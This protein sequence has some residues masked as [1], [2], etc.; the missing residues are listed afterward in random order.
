MKRIESMGPSILPY[1]VI[2]GVLLFR[3]EI[4]HPYN[5]V[6]VSSCL[7]IFAATRAVR[8]FVLPLSALVGVDIFLTT[9][10]YGYPL[11]F[12]AVVT[13]AFYLAAMLLGSGLLRTS[14][15]WRCVAGCS[16]LASVSFFLVSNFTVWAAWQ[17]YPKSLEGLGACY[18]AALPFFLNSLTSELCFSL[19][20]FGL[21][22]RVRSLTAVEIAPN[23]HC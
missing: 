3:L 7:F 12:D 13:W 15:S 14:H 8:E 20:L 16:L 23:A 6:P 18:V 10:R 9:H 2:L 22:D 5:C 4:S 21:M 1:I 19:L 17:M 11:T